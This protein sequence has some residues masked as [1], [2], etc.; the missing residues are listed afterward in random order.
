MNEQW[1]KIIGFDLTDR[2][3][4]IVIILRYKTIYNFLFLNLYWYYFLQE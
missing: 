2:L 4:A 3:N 1:K